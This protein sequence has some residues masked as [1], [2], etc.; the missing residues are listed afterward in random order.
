MQIK[1]H[2]IALSALLLLT[3]ATSF[4]ALTYSRNQAP[5]VLTVS[6]QADSPDDLIESG[7]APLSSNACGNLTY[8]EIVVTQVLGSD[9]YGNPIYQYYTSP[10]YPMDDLQETYS[11]SLPAG[12]YN[13]I[14]IGAS[15]D[16]ALQPNGIFTNNSSFSDLESSNSCSA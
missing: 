9:E 3:P 7:C 15:T 14:Q 16:N 12:I 5:K 4:G 13:L 2:L 11:F 6:V 8:W 1:K 10:A